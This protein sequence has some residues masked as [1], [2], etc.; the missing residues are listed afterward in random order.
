M[1]DLHGNVA[2]QLTNATLGVTYATRYDPWGEVVDTGPDSGSG[3]VAPTTWTYQGRLDVSPTGLATPLLDGGA[4]PR[5]CGRFGRQVGS[6]RV[7]CETRT[8][9]SASSRHGWTGSIGPRSSS[10]LG[11]YC[12]ER[13]SQ[14]RS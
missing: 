10:A 6:F 12:S 7:G 13:G 9:N 11:C 3:P 8:A 5:R 4:R 2:A 1:P 14:S